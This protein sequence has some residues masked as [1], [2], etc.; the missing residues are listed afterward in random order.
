MKNKDWTPHSWKWC[1]I[2]TLNMR[3]VFD[4]DRWSFGPC[5]EDLVREVFDSYAKFPY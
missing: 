3:N 1:N 4:T 2:N 5:Y